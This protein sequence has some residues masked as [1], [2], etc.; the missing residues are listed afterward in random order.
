[1]RSAGA[2]LPADLS[3]G[4]L[5]DLVGGRLR[6]ALQEPARPPRSPASPR[7]P[8]QEAGGWP[9]PDRAA[10]V[11]PLTLPGSAH[12]PGGRDRAA[13]PPSGRAWPAT[14]APALGGRGTAATGPPSPADVAMAAGIRPLLRVAPPDPAHPAPVATRPAEASGSRPPD[15]T[16]PAT[17]RRLLQRWWSSSPSATDRPSY[18]PGTGVPAGPGRPAAQAP[19][20]GGTSADRSWPEVVARHAARQL[21]STGTPGAPPLRAQQHVSTTPDKVEIQNVFNVE[22][23]AAGA[24]A[25]L[26]ELAEQ[27]AAVLREQALQHGVD[28][29]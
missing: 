27:L 9:T 1:V 19:T 3:G 25:G 21:R 8:S 11:T 16:H 13:A 10:P 17:L 24:G 6:E 2:G 28:I 20:V 7:R 5:L 18:D 12:P 15:G 29:A 26:D 14:A 23:P 22:L 4:P